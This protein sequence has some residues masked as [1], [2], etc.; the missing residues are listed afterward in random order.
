[1]KHHFF[2]IIEA[3]MAEVK[4]HAHSH[5]AYKRRPSSRGTS[6]LAAKKSKKRRLSAPA[7]KDLDKFLSA[8][9][10]KRILDRSSLGR[11]SIPLRQSLVA[12]LSDVKTTFSKCEIQR[13][14]T[15]WQPSRCPAEAEAAVDRESSS[16]NSESSS[17]F[18]QSDTETS[19][20]SAASTGSDHGR[21]RESADAAKQSLVWLDLEM[22]GL[23]VDSDTILEIAVIVT[24]SDLTIVDAGKS[25][26]VAHNARVLEGMNAWSAKQHVKSG[27]VKRVLASTCSLKTAEEAMISYIKQTIAKL[28]P[29]G[30]FPNRKL[31]LAGSCVHV[32]KKFLE[33]KMPA[34][35][36]LFSHRTVDVATIRELAKRWR[37]KLYSSIA[38]KVGQ[39]SVQHRALE[40]VKISILELR[41]YKKF[42]FNGAL[43]FADM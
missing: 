24:N 7:A 16:G 39:A 13:C 30:V 40:D 5:K 42:L 6:V 37:P 26:V 22:T 9:D 8:S 17:E 12:H 4:Q 36:A 31:M 28:T 2:N 23:D 25:M 27:L 10:K 1:M 14:L 38:R 18:A 19:I 3:T 41:S 15:K 21:H 33:K 11:G 29:T 20:C 32:D 43:D 34:L 35:A